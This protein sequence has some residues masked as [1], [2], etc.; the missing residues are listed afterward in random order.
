MP[1][2]KTK[3]TYLEMRSAPASRV[4]PPCDGVEI[5]WAKSPSRVEYL[6]WYQ[7][8]G[9]AWLW[10][11][12]LQMVAENLQTLLDDPGVVVHLLLVDQQ[13]AGFVEID[14]RNR[15]E[16]EIKYFGLFPAFIGRGLGKYF[17]NAIADH[18]W[19]QGPQRLWL[20]TCDVDHA[21]ALPNYLQAGFEI[22]D[23]KLVD[24]I[25]P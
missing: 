6:T 20:H 19:Q 24:K 18:V 13:P 15:D 1:S 23:E 9:E 16:I 21:A 10:T 5:V 22:F 8:V 7:A 25:V 3:T 2:I 14:G 11:D 17:L 4:E 12:R